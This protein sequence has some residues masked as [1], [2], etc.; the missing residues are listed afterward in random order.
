[1]D[2]IDMSEREYW[3]FVA[4]RPGMFI[5]RSNLSGLEAFLEGYDQHSM[6][7]GGP[8][9]SGWL[10]SLVARRGRDCNHGW[11]GQVRHVALPDGWEHWEL[12]A[13]QEEH[14]IK[15]LFELLDEFLAE[16][17]AKAADM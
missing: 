15:V 8:G 10:E 16:R 13:D 1:M 4:K 3:A 11:S 9:L 14:V 17:E 5:G 12:S 7:H 6:R 2:L